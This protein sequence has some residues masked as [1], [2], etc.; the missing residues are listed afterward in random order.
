MA[1]RR[2]AEPALRPLRPAKA[3][4]RAAEQELRE[5]RLALTQA[6]RWRRRGMASLVRD[7]SEALQAALSK[8]EVLERAAAPHTAR[9]GA[10]ENDLRW[11]EHEA[12]VARIRDRLDRL[13]IEPP[14]RSTEL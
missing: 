6:P 14:S 13:R 7:A 4:L 2:A 3:E 8:V 12:S 5:R 1:A 11:A 10:P 9:V